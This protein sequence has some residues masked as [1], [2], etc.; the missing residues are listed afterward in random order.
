MTTIMCSSC[1][2]L[3]GI[4][5]MTT[6]TS[7]FVVRPSQDAERH[8]RR[9]SVMDVHDGTAA[10]RETFDAVAPPS[11][12]RLFT[13]PGR[14]SSSSVFQGEVR[15]AKT[16]PLD[17]ETQFPVKRRWNSGN[18]RVWGKRS[19]ALSHVGDHP[20]GREHDEDRVGA[21][22]IWLLPARAIDSERLHLLSRT[23]G[24]SRGRL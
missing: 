9:P 23:S 20:Y 21:Y 11:S 2:L 13:A 3:L 4:L 1:N 12:R 16:T 10:G 14:R 5:F 24:P 15:D 22:R 8:R 19:P 17:D 6:M 18:L 7:S